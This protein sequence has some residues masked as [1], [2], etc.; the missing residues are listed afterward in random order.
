MNQSLGVERVGLGPE[1]K[2][3]FCR[4]AG[5][6]SMGGNK[7]GRRTFDV[8]RKSLSGVADVGICPKGGT[9]AQTRSNDAFD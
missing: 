7:T 4:S 2:C 8:V 9:Y 5:R 6:G 1:G 3:N